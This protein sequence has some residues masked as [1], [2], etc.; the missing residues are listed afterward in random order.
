MKENTKKCWKWWGYTNNSL[1]NSIE[2]KIKKGK[3]LLPKP[4][5]FTKRRKKMKMKLKISKR[6]KDWS[7]WRSK[8]W[9]S[10]L[11]NLKRRKIVRSTNSSVKQ[12]SSW[13]NW[14]RKC[15]FKKEMTKMRNKRNLIRMKLMTILPMLLKTQTRSIT[16]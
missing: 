14:A 7:F 5:T 1:L 13:K 4:E 2:R 12:I 9:A 15:W 8:I 3:K 6:R 16:I 11:T 10:I